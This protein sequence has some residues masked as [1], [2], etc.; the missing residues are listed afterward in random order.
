MGKRRLYDEEEEDQAPE[1]TPDESLRE[2]SFYSY[3]QEQYGGKRTGKGVLA[4]ELARLAAGNDQVKGI[5]TLDKLIALTGSIQ[6]DKAVAE[7][8]ALLWEEYLTATGQ[9]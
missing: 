1:E 7:V 2:A 8:N 5:D 6:N 4:R 3:M 9:W